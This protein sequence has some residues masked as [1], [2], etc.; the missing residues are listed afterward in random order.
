VVVGAAV[1]WIHA[2]HRSH[3]HPYV[4]IWAAHHQADALILPPAQCFS[5]RRD[6]AVPTAE[7]SGPI[8]RRKDKKAII[9]TEQLTTELESLAWSPDAYR[10]GERVDRSDTPFPVRLHLLGDVAGLFDLTS[11][12]S[13]VLTVELLKAIDRHR[14]Y[15][16]AYDSVM[17][18]ALLESSITTVYGMSMKQLVDGADFGMLAQIIAFVFRAE[19]WREWSVQ[20]RGAEETNRQLDVDIPMSLRSVGAAELL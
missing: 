16:E 3:S 15:S 14:D 4:P 19:A 20:T 6:L 5:R 2:T 11:G 13:L 10:P 12:D 17:R 8:V 18:R 9:K 1:G 7:Y